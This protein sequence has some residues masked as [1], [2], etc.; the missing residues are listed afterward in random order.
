MPSI[1]VDRKESARHVRI[2]GSAKSRSTSDIDPK[3]TE[4]QMRVVNRAE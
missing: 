1:G 3:A 4:A 2:E